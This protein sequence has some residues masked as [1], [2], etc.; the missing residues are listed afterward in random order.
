MIDLGGDRDYDD[1]RYVVN[2]P[3][4]TTTTTTTYTPGLRAVSIIK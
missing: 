2:C 3:Q 1:I 4:V